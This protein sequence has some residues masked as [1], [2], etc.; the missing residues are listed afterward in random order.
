[1]NN[2][3][4]LK[5]NCFQRFLNKIGLLVIKEVEKP[6]ERVIVKE[7]KVPVEKIIYKDKCKFKN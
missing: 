6:V 5:L 2:T 1:M 3:S 7:I 4:K